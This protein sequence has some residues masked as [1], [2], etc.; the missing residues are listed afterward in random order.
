MP[1]N[2]LNFFEKTLDKKTGSCYTLDVRKREKDLTRKEGKKMKVYIVK[3]NGS[4]W[5]VYATKEAAEE[6]KKDANL[7]A[8]MGGTWGAYMVK[9]YEVEA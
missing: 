5:G 6:A 1:K 3:M 4:I 9:E 8:E 7:D 2:F